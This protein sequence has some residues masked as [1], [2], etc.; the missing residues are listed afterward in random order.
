MQDGVELVGKAH[1][2]PYGRC[3]IVDAYRVASVA[4]VL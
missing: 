4:D 1:L 2:F 3:A